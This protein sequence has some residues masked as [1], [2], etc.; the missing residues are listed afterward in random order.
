MVSCTS[1]FIFITYTLIL[2]PPDSLEQYF[3]AISW[4]TLFKNNTKQKK[5]FQSF[6]NAAT[7]KGEPVSPEITQEKNK[8][9]T[10]KE[11]WP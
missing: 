6:V 4:A 3:R 10:N 2:F 9:P 1:F 5:M 7:P 11:Y 8:Q